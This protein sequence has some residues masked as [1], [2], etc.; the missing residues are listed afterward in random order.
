MPT[1]TSSGQREQARI[2]GLEAKQ[3]TQDAAIKRWQTS[4]RQLEVSATG[5]WWSAWHCR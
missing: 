1:E 5:G 2:E 4:D 3:I